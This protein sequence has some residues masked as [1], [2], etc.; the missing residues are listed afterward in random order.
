[1]TG[2]S[3]GGAVLAASLLL[4]LRTRRRSQYRYRRPGRTIAVPEPQLTPVEKTITAA[5]ELSAPSITFLDAAL[6][7]LAARLPA[8][9][10]L[11]RWTPGRGWVELLPTIRPPPG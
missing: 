6:R 11:D 3:G 2:L 7:R 10:R 5:G 1:M 4:L 8:A 9:N